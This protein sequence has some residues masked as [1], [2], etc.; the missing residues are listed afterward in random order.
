[1]RVPSAENAA[2]AMDAAVS[3]ISAP[4]SLG[5]RRPSSTSCVLT[6]KFVRVSVARPPGSPTDTVI[7]ARNGKLVCGIF[8]AAASMLT[9]AWP[10]ASV[11]PASISCASAFSTSPSR[12][13]DQPRSATGCAIA[14]QLDMCRN[15]QIRRGRAVQIPAGHIDHRRRRLGDPLA[16]RRQFDRQPVRHEILH[17]HIQRPDQ[18]LRARQALL[19]LPRAARR[20]RSSAQCL[21]PRRPP[22]S[23]PGAIS[24][25]PPH[26]AG[27]AKPK[28]PAPPA[29]EAPTGHARSC[30]V[31]C[32]S[33]GR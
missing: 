19:Q 22:R 25:L 24:P 23:A 18:R 26:P 31:G 33:P 15:V 17:L 16:F 2:T 20:G 5:A 8:S 6:F 9:E 32:V 14:L 30:R 4:S 13:K 28:R 7:S 12:P 21:S 29:M 11:F 10:C 1:M 27:A 3:S